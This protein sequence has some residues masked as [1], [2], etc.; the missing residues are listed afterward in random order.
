MWLLRF[1]FEK[2]NHP[3]KEDTTMRLL[4]TLGTAFFAGTFV[5]GLSLSAQDLA[6][7]ATFG[8][9]EGKGPRGPM[10][11]KALEKF[12]KDGD[13]KLNEEERKA[14]H[15]AFKKNH[16]EMH[17]KMLEKFDKDGDGKLN[18][19]ERQAMR[20]AH[21]EMKGKRR[22]MLLEKFDA[23]GDG[24]LSP[25]E[26]KAAHEAFKEEHPELHKKMLEKFDTDGDGKLSPEERSKAHEARKEH[27]KDR[28]PPRK[29]GDAAK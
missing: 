29:G 7:E 1:R 25:E 5:L 9:P 26:H 12:D 14:A 4:R 18:E 15:E 2:P 3:S 23:D 27:R 19:E 21:R 8:P 11:K 10:H 22:E 24:K 20:E 28:R 13:G 17:K 6:D 16:P